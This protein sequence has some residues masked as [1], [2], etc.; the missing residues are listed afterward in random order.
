MLKWAQIAFK[1]VSPSDD[2]WTWSSGIQIHEDVHHSGN[3][4]LIFRNWSTSLL[5][6]CFVWDNLSKSALSFPCSKF[7]NS[8][9]AHAWADRAKSVVRL[10]MMLFKFSEHV[11]LS[12]NFSICSI[13]AFWAAFKSSNWFWSSW[14]SFSAAYVKIIDSFFRW[15]LCLQSS[16]DLQ[17]NL[18][19]CHCWVLQYQRLR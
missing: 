11:P 17:I 12:N 6:F 1:L 9:L 3:V 18:R 19:R 4:S 8:Q 13:L 2:E 7:L 14:Y 5:K 16:F 15:K 10:S